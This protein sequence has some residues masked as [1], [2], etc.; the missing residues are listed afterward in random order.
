M[1]QAL[2]QDVD[3]AVPEAGGDDQ[4]FA[5]D[6]GDGAGETRGPCGA[7]GTDGG[8]ASLVDEDYS[9]LNR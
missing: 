4:A 1:E 8:N 9:I 3:M 5:I 2:G 6:D 7:A